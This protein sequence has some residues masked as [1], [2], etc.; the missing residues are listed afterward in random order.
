MDY[1][2]SKESKAEY[3]HM[4]NLSTFEM[5]LTVP[6]E[7]AFFKQILQHMWKK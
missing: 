2:F 1:D 5:M 7:L 6:I 3:F 4:K